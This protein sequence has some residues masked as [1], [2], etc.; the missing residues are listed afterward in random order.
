MSSQAV[1]GKG[2]LF[3]RWDGT[4]WVDLN[5]VVTITGPGM[6]RNVIDVTS[7]S[8]TGGYT[9][10]ITGFRDGGTVTLAMIFRRDNYNTMKTDFESDTLRNYEILLPDDE[11]TSLEFEGLVTELPLTIPPDDKV[12]MDVSIKISGEVTCNSGSGSS[13]D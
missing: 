9:E 6:S 5:E 4:D 11:S 8:S 10:F 12:T 7:L 2:T 3:R 1:A 13:A